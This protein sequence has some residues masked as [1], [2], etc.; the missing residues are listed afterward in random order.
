VSTAPAQGSTSIQVVAAPP[1]GEEADPALRD[2]SGMSD[3]TSV[4][5]APRE[6]Q[7]L[8]RL[9]R[10]YQVKAGTYQNMRQ[11]MERAKITQRLGESDEGTKFKILEPARLPLRPVRPNLQKLFFLALLLGMFVGAGA[12][13]AAEFLDRSFQ[14]AE[15][16]QAT[17]TLPVIGSI[18]T[19]VTEQDMADRRQRRKRW[20]S[21]KTQLELLKTYVFNPVWIRVDKLFVKWGL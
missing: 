11:R 10:D 4:S 14:S 18:S 17:L 6:Q 5:L 7:E 9:T 8:A 16:L 3:A 19:I 21:Y 15:D 20:V 12:A 13:F 1:P 2:V